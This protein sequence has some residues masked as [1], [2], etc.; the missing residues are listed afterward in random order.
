MKKGI[1]RYQKHPT[2][3]DRYEIEEGLNTNHTLTDIA[4]MLAI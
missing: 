4:E 2:L 1:T 3:Q